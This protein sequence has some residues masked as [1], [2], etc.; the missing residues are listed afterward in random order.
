[1]ENLKDRCLE[2]FEQKHAA[3]QRMLD[4]TKAVTFTNDEANA[5]KEAEAFIALYERRSNILTRIEKI[6]D[7]LGL[8][9]P[10]E[11][12]D[13]QD[14]EFQ[15]K[16][17]A[18]REQAKDIARKLVEIDKSNMTVYEKLTN[19]LKEN[20]RSARQNMDLNK[21]YS[22]DFEGIEGSFLDRKN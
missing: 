2:L 22:D 11:A 17:V 12:D 10:L 21:K 18:F 19:Y 13:M 9:D 1:M 20:M 5:E 4:V 8:L 14:A 6:D 16:V 15:A 3:L 7:A